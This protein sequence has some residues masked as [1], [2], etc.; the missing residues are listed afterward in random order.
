M[1]ISSNMIVK[2]QITLKLKSNKY[3]I[4]ISIY[5]K[6][7]LSRS[8]ILDFF[9]SGPKIFQL[10]TQA[11]TLLFRFCAFN[12]YIKGCPRSRCRF[13]VLFSRSH[14]MKC[15]E[16]MYVD[17]CILT[18]VNFFYRIVWAISDIFSS[19]V[20][21]LGIHKKY[22]LSAYQESLL[23]VPQQQCFTIMTAFL[24]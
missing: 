8:T 6:I 5:K 14:K 1:S 7:M 15:F 16:Q 22:S 2:F 3:W 17:W 12:Q 19:C 23:Q 18:T 11:N 4:N 20:I 10:L 21:G 24:K 13:W 9:G